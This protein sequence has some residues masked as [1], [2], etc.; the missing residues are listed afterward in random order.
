MIPSPNDAYKYALCMELRSDCFKYAIVHAENRQVAFFKA[1]EFDGL[2]KSNLVEL[3]NEDFF[4]LDY[5]SISVSVSTMRSTLVP[6]SIFNNSAP[7]DIFKLNHTAPID[8][9]DYSRL[10]ALGLVT[11]YEIPLWIKS[12]FVKRFLRIKILHHSAVLLKGIFNRPAFKPRAHILKEKNLFYIVLTDK[13]KLTYFNAFDS[14][15]V[16]DLVYYYL[17][18]LDQKEID[19]NTLP[20][21]LYGLETRHEEV[22]EMNEILT[23]KAEVDISSEKSSNFILINQLL[24]V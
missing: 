21:K 17:F 20:L 11:I 22:K 7:K 18:V 16:S 5:K 8:N 14:G 9:I 13:N 3:L 24:C 1:I 2:E 12:I 19:A 4:N 15:K 23:K 6:E 10:P